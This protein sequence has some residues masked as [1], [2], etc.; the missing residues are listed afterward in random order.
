VAFLTPDNKVVIL[1][2][3]N[4][5]TKQVFNIESSGTSFTTELAAGE[6]ATYVLSLWGG[7]K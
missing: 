1:V 7:G 5:D 2:L 6:V 4:I 3:N